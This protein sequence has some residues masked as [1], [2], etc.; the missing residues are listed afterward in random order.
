[1]MHAEADVFREVLKF[2]VGRKSG[3]RRK[4]GA[5]VEVG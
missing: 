4:V 3:E 1:M 5:E 2:Q